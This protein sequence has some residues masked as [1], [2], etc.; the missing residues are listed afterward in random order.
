ME[1]ETVVWG[2]PHNYYYN[3]NASFSTPRHHVTLYNICANLPLKLYNNGLCP[4]PRSQRA[5]KKSLFSTV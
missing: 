2:R 1:V 3:N 4:Y 5:A